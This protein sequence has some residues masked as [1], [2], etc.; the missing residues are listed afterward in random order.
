MKILLTGATG[1]I[2]GHL[3]KKL[4]EF[5]HEV[6][7]LTRDKKQ[8]PAFETQ[9]IELSDLS[10]EK[11]I[12]AVIHL[13]GA[14]VAD[15]KWN[16]DYKRTLISSRVAF[17]H[18]I[19]RELDYEDLQVFLQASATGYYPSS[20]DR[21]LNEDSES[22]NGFLSK[23][24]VDWEETTHSLDFRKAYFRIGMVVG[25]D[26][27]AIK[28]MKP[29]FEKRKGVVLG[30]GQQYMS[31]VHIDDLVDMFV[32]ALEDFDYNGVY[33]AVSPNPLTNKDFTYVMSKVVG[34]SVILPAVPSF[35]LK[36]L[37]GEMSQILLDSYRVEPRN[38]KQRDFDF[39]YSDMEEALRASI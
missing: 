38:L 15:K 33:N 8:R 12:E 13:A 10:V 31:W 11:G 5:D 22:G 3:G 18:K 36:V 1:Y 2:G 23:L 27:P 14:S 37:Y 9:L 21:I 20:D 26:S 39:K 29:L 28:K 25:K 17:T 19:L 16:A 6:V 24:C 30:S 35:V 34:K 4:V 32:K 7:S